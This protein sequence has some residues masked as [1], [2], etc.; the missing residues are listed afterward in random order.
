MALNEPSWVDAMHEELNQFEKLRV[1]QL[2]E[3]PKGKKFWTC[4]RFSEIS[5]MITGLFCKIKLVW[6]FAVSGR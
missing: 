3:L 1:W 5:K 4:A 6:L 2:V